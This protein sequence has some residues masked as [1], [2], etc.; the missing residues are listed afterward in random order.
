[1]L[2][3]ESPEGGLVL[4]PHETA[5][6]PGSGREEYAERNLLRGSS[7]PDYSRG[8]QNSGATI[9]LAGSGERRMSCCRSRHAARSHLMALPRQ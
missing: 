8:A 2:S 1:M 9:V 7:R 3:G 4:V 6:E 5:S